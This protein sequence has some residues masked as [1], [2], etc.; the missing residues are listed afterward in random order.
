MNDTPEAFQALF[1]QKMMERS[2]EERLLMGD[3]MFD[4]A[5]RL[6]LAS[7]PKNLSPSERLYRLFLRFYSQ[8][9]NQETKKKIKLRFSTL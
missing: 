3:R 7:F 2:G 9:F 4:S 1:H 8:D 6:A 5:R